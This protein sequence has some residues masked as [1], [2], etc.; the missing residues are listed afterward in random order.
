MV[1]SDLYTPLPARPPRRRFRLPPAIIACGALALLGGAVAVAT[2]HEDDSRGEPFA[3]GS[4]SVATP[5]EVSP[6][7]APPPAS[8]QASSVDAAAEADVKAGRQVDV[9]NG[10]MVIRAAI[11]NGSTP[12]SLKVPDPVQSKAAFAPP[13]PQ[14]LE[15]SATGPLPR[16]SRD[17]RRPAKLYAAAPV[18]SDGKPRIA[19]IVGGMGLD[20]AATIEAG[21]LLP[22]AV[23]F[24]FAPYGERLAEQVAETR[25]AGHEVILQLPMEDFGREDR[26]FPHMLKA[27]TPDIIERLHWLMSRFSGYAGV[28]NYLGGRLLADEGSLRP[29]LQEIAARGLYFVDDGTAPRSL[30]TPLARDLALPSAKADVV[31]DAKDDAASMIAAMT[32]LEG[33]ARERGFAV[34]TATGRS[35]TNTTIGHYLSEA[36][37][38]GI[39]IIPLSQAV[40]ETSAEAV[41]KRAQA[42]SR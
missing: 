22:A 5:A 35:A 8:V 29:I 9:E 16:I 6:I 33:L 12:I 41:S 31:I 36:A 1:G 37:K 39:V 4:I 40:G 3:V 28:E 23:T 34:G 19:L 38:R 32:R 10:V 14:L 20:Q 11:S 17:G 21:T 2:M 30:A 18:P 25:A 27:E 7:A 15:P 24:G 42:V 13:E 26:P